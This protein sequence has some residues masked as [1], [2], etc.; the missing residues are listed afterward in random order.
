MILYTEEK[1][2]EGRIEMNQRKGKMK[3]LDL[4]K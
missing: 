4:R 3:F 2:T 1:K